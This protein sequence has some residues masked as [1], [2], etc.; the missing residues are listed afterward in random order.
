MVSRFRAAALPGG[1]PFRVAAFFK[2]SCPARLALIEPCV[3]VFAAVLGVYDEVFPWDPLFKSGSLNH[4]AIH[5]RVPSFTAH[6]VL[7]RLLR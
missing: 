6:C 2:V 3:K 7:N 5:G 4:S 1:K